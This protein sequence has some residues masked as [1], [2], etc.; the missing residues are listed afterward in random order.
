V[1]ESPLKLGD[2]SFSIIRAVAPLVKQQI[3]GARE[4]REKNGVSKSEAGR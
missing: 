3:K 4:E 1:V 2:V